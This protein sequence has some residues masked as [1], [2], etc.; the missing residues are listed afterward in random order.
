MSGTEKINITLPVFMQREPLPENYFQPHDPYKTAPS[1]KVKI[2]AMAEYAR[3]NGKKCW[4]L[5][6]EEF[7]MFKTV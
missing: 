1:C 4:E 5:T 2:G 3:K 6:K 7:A